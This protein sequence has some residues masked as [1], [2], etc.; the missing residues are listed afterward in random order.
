MLGCA[1]DL[2]I[3]EFLSL[4]YIF[5]SRAPEGKVREQVASSAR[6][7]WLLPFVAAAGAAALAAAG[8]IGLREAPDAQPARA[9]TAQRSS[10]PAVSKGQLQKSTR[11]VRSLPPAVQLRL[12]FATVFGDAASA[13]RTID[14]ETL[15]YT[16]AALEWIGDKAALLSFGRNALDCHACFGT[17]GIHYLKPIGGR[18]EVS[19]AWPTQIG[20][21]AWGA[22]TN[23]MSISRNFSSYPVVMSEYGDMNQG[24]S[25]GGVS[26]TELR[27]EGP[28]RWG[29]V[30]TGFSD[31]NPYSESD[32][33]KNVSGEITDIQR[34]RSFKVVYK[35][36]D[37]FT[38][39]YVRRGSKFVLT[40]KETRMP[41][42]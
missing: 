17:I 2:V 11:D 8:W 10:E 36:D 23:D 29:S 16:P 24:C 1:R 34:D 26:L 6:K 21:T 25:S 4:V 5:G 7:A 28:S 39:T 14:G 32:R 20:G 27:P 13:T 30:R 12:A 41:V 35:G 37:S 31:A 38:E 3:G 42:C 33:I 15:T 9:P 22:P 40:A 19:G 18:F